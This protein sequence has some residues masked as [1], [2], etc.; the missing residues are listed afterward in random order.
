MGFFGS[1]APGTTREDA[2]K[3]V[4]PEV[5]MCR[6]RGIKGFWTSW[7]W[8]AAHPGTQ[9]AWIKKCYEEGHLLIVLPSDELPYP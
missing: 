7:E 6:T 3:D 2:K 9:G 5:T 1:W 4:K 8:M